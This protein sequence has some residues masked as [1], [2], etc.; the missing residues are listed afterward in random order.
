V[1]VVFIGLG[2]LLAACSGE[3]F[4]GTRE[5]AS[6]GGAGATGEA[7]EEATG[8]STAGRGGSG[9]SSAPGGDGGDDSAGG[10]VT[11]GSATGGSS[12]AAEGGSASGGTAG[13]AGVGLGGSAA[14]AGGSI[15]AGMSGSGG[16]GGVC[17]PAS[18]NAL[19]ICSGPCPSACV[20][21]RDCGTGSCVGAG[22]C[23]NNPDQ[24]CEAG[25]LCGPNDPCVSDPLAPFPSPTCAHSTV[26]RIPRGACLRVTGVFKVL[27]PSSCAETTP[28]NECASFTAVLQ[29]PACGQPGADPMRCTDNAAVCDGEYMLATVTGG[30]ASRSTNDC[31]CQ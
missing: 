14:G 2:V 19:R 22:T 20:T 17:V 25:T 1:R 29:C 18:R 28:M 12:G 15:S 7:G 27:N 11:G 5:L 21:E 10:A 31:F 3:A 23:E 30:S 24:L 13:G 16:T 9:G 6:S 4:E 8:G 26:Y